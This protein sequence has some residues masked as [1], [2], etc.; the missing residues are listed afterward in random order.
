VLLLLQAL[1]FHPNEL[2]ETDGKH[3]AICQVAH[4]PIQLAPIPKI[5]FGL[6]RAAFLAFSA[7]PHPIAVFASFSLFCRPPPLV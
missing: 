1:H 2:A 5:R 3:C 7:D 4:A 6:S